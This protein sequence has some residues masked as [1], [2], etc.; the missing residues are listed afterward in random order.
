[1]DI[2]M[3]SVDSLLKTYPSLKR[4]PEKDRVR[5]FSM[6]QKINFSFDLHQVKCSW[7][8]HEMPAR[9]DA[10]EKYVQGKKYQQLLKK[11]FDNNSLEK[12]KEFLEPSTKKNHE[13]V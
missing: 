2:D 10:I 13:Q 8:E 5:R 3:N 6:I 4:V 9:A 7:T 11:K 1:M 12:F